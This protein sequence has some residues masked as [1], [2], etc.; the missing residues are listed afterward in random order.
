MDPTPES[1][2]QAKKD[3]VEFS[4]S[5]GNNGYGDPRGIQSLR[6]NLIKSY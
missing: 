4:A 6:E 2:V 3:F 5:T 1:I